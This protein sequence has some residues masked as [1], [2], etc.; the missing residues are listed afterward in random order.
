MRTIRLFAFLLITAIMLPLSSQAA[1][2]IYQLIDSNNFKSEWNDMNIFAESEALAVIDKSL[3]INYNFDDSENLC[4]D[5]SGN[6]NDGIIHGNV[7]S[8][9]GKNEKGIRFKSSGGNSDAYVELPAS[10]FDV[11]EVTFMTWAKYDFLGVG[12]NVRLFA[13]E[14]GD[15]KS[16]NLKTHV[17]TCLSG[18]QPILFTGKNSYTVLKTA[19]MVPEDVYQDWHHV[20]VSYDGENIRFFI[21]GALVNSIKAKTDFH[22]WKITNAFLGKTSQVN[23]ISTYNGYMDDVRIYSRALSESEI[24][25]A[26]GISDE[27]AQRVVK[28]LS[29]L[30]IGGVTPTEFSVFSDDYYCVLSED[31]LVPPEVTAEAPCEGAKLSIE[32]ADKLPGIATI[33]VT[34]PS[35]AQR[36]VTVHLTKTGQESVHPEIKDVV[37]DDPFWNDKLKMFCEVTAPYILESWVTKTL[38]NLGNF[39]KVAAGHRNTQDYVG[40]MTWGEGDFYA[41]MAGSCRLL[42]QY[43]NEKLKNQILG[44]I[45]H[46]FAAS[47]NVEK[48]YFSIYHLLQTN[49]KVFTETAN[50]AAHGAIFN[51]GYLLELGMALYDTMGD[52]RMLRAGMR[53]LNFTVSYSNHGQ[54][55][56]VAYHQAGEYFIAKFPGWLEDHLEVLENEYISDIP[57][58][59]DD[60][61]EIARLLLSNRGNHTNRIN[62]QIYTA[63]NNDHIPFQKIFEATGHAAGCQHLYTALSEYGRLTGDLQYINACYRLYQNLVNRQLYLTGSAGAIGA[64]EGLCGD[65]CLPNESYSETCTTGA[66]ILYSDTLSRMFADAEYSEVIENA[67]YN[68]MLG[69]IGQDGTGFFYENPLSSP[70]VTRYIWHSVPCCTKYVC[71]I[72]GDLPRYIYSFNG[73]DVFVNQYIGNKATLRLESGDV[74]LIQTANW[75]EQ[76][77]AQVTISS[78]AD[79]IGNLYLRLPEWSDNTVVTINGKNIT[80][81]E[82][83]N[84][85]LI[86]KG[87]LKDG[88]EIRISADASPRRVYANENVA[89]DAGKVA[90]QKG[91]VVYCMEG[92]DNPET[93]QGPAYN[94]VFLPEES[95]F[96]EI[97]IDDLYGGITALRAT[98]EIIYQNGSTSPYNLTLIPFYARTNRGT[99]SVAVWLNEDKSIITDRS[100]YFGKVSELK[101]IGASYTVVSNS[102]NPGGGG[103]KDISV[104]IDG[105][106][107]YQNNTQ[108]YDTFKATLTDDLGKKEKIEWIGVTFDKEY[109]VTH[110]V[111]WEGGH[112]NDGGWFGETPFVQVLIDG[113]WIDVVTT[114]SPEYPDDSGESQAPVNE[115][116]VFTLK[117]PIICS[118]ARVLGKQNHLAGHYSCAE[119]E[120]YGVSVENFPPEAEPEANN[121]R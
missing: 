31:T 107:H 92:V 45:D 87:G 16:F 56:F 54:R 84:G 6:S 93:I 76:G 91:P 35:G 33:N 63:Y 25:L 99:S 18:Y 120:V 96:E 10:A 44:Y 108:Q 66:L 61:Y 53:F 85:F 32:Q 115:S 88:D 21:N 70:A 49:G 22:S 117:D 9:S 13:L 42:E 23:N 110:I 51:L 47:E 97:K 7:I 95:N 48:G 50:V 28:L 73:N 82:K 5:S 101:S 83:Y 39:D 106:K 19:G 72:F 68:T 36:T 58:N 112:W 64:Y 59:I 4:A 98:A 60:Y 17:D 105:N 26:S 8:S 3:I 38:D 100:V 34:F 102:K 69:N 46:I 2:G 30:K 71:L 118:G 90:V 89:A 86:I 113:E 116:Y 67:L 103:S 27:K 77:I 81:Y 15:N 79:I 24:K 57:V 78:G 111:F 1:V 40:S 109:G 52:A 75:A 121:D 114:I 43:P 20:A 29:G 74:K 12:N 80:D 94:W 37:I 119:F 62:G 104:V 11:R 41:A 65:Y 55:N 14:T